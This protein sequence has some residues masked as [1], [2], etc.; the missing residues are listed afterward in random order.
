[1]SK[2]QEVVCLGCGIVRIAE[3]NARE[4]EKECHVTTK[5]ICKVCG[6]PYVETKGQALEIK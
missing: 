2:R 1:M 5:Y 3:I 4:S 6:C